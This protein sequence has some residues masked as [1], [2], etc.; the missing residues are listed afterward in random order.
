MATTVPAFITNRPTTAQDLLFGDMLHL[1]PSVVGTGKIFATVQD[2][3]VWMGNIGI[4]NPQIKIHAGAYPTET[5]TAQRSVSITTDGTVTGVIG[6]QEDVS[7]LDT[8]QIHDNEVQC[9]D[10]A[11]VT[12]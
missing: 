6:Y 7:L 9:F 11:I 5:I 3:I 10:N 2:A 12:Y 8:I 1:F 4:Q